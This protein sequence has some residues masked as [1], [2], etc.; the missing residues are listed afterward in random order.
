[1]SEPIYIYHSVPKNLTGDILYPLNV[2]KE[3]YPE[4]YEKEVAKYVGRERV[5]EQ[6]IPILNCLWND[7][8]HFSPVHPAKIKQAMI[9]AGKDSNYEVQA[10]KVDSTLIDPAK[11][12][13]YLHRHRE[14]IDDDFLPF[15]LDKISELSEVP[16]F[17]KNYYQR[18]FAAGE[19]PLIYQRVPHILY[20]GTLDI[21]KLEKIIV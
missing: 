15:N 14:L 17:T 10:Y 21:P 7:V 2:L 4:V 11:A 16:E 6:K 12:V 3:K 5:M 19:R 13:I 9:E 18:S 20:R 8:L 1:M